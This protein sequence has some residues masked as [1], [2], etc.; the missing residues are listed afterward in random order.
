MAENK[1]LATAKRKGEQAR[2]D[3]KAE[4]ENPYPDTRTWRGHVTFA[5]AFRRAWAEGWREEDARHG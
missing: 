1:A 5:R 3:G 4:T 2:R